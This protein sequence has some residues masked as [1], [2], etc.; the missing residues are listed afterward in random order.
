M[1]KTRKEPKV[2]PRFSIT[3]NENMNPIVGNGETLRLP[4]NGVNQA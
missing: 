4:F 1:A 2:R 3:G